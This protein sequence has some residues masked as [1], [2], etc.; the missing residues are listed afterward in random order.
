MTEMFVPKEYTA[1]TKSGRDVLLRFPAEEYAAR[2][3]ATRKRMREEGLDALL[4][5]AQESHYWLTGFDTAGYVFFQAGVITADDSE[6][7]VLTRTP[8]KRQAEVAS[9]YDEVRIWLNAEDANP[10][11]DLRGILEEKGLKGKKVG[12]EYATYGLTA[13][14]GRTVDAALQGFCETAD[15]SWIIRGLR[16]VKSS[17]ELEH[18]RIAGK[19]A[20]AAVRATI[21]RV[22]PGIPDSALVGAAA[23]AMLSLGG[24][25]PSGGPMVNAG[26]AALFGRSSGIAHTIEAQ[27]QV[28]VELAGSHCRY[29]VCIENTLTVGPVDPRQERQM[30]VA[31]DALEEIKANALPGRELGTLDDIHRRVLDKGGFAKARYAACGYALGCTFKPTWMDVPPMIYSG[32]P[33]VMQPGM[34][35]FVHIMIPDTDTGLVAGIGQTFVIRETGAPE[36]FSDLPIELFRC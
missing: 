21:A 10:A 16:L 28:L 12:I 1:K 35:F 2:L 19:L 29:H 30:G 23:D 33:L 13:F 34:V 18:V 26:A 3:T 20:D 14:N 7:V 4:V 9:L 25:M 17:A 11:M 5:F 15:G 8:D 36:V 24:D 32:N 6:T 31:R 22:K 27:D